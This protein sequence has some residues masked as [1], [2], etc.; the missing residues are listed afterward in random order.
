MLLVGLPLAL[1]FAYI[2]EFTPVGLKKAVDVDQTGVVVALGPIAHEHLPEH[3]GGEIH[4]VE[5]VEDVAALRL[6]SDADVAYVTQ[7]TL[8]VDDTKDIIAALHARFTRGW[9]GKRIAW[10]A[11]IGFLAVAFTYYGVNF[12]LS[13][14]HS[15][16]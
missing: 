4:L 2:Y 16:G 12:L 10:I 5:S 8:S 13:G 11:I 15:Y 3:H 9:G 6:P 1:Y 7:T 14:L